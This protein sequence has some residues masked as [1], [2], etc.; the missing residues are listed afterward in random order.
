MSASKDDKLS[1]KYIFESANEELRRAM[2]EG[3][4]RTSEFEH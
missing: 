1:T 2:M 4:H 3:A